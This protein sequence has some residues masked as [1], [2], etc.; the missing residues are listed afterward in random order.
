MIV[1]VLLNVVTEPK[2]NSSTQRDSNIIS[3]NLRFDLEWRKDKTEGCL[4]NQE[5]K[6]TPYP[7]FED[8]NGEQF[9]SILINTDTRY[10]SNHCKVPPRFKDLAKRIFKSHELKSYDDRAN[11]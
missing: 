8:H 3:G 10:D 2:S 7:D 1:G 5:G 9:I 6:A 4:G 11:R